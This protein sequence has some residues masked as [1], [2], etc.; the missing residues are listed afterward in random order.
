M[1]ERLSSELSSQFSYKETQYS[2]DTWEIVGEEHHS[3][4]FMPMA[5]EIVP[6]E[7]KLVD[8]MF[9]DYGGLSKVRTGK[10][11][12]LP[13]GVGPQDVGVQ[14]RAG[15]EEIEEL[16]KMFEQRLEHATQEALEEG[17]QLGLQEAE[18]L[19]KK[20]ISEVEARVS[21][22][23]KDMAAQLREHLQR[24]EKSAVELAV[25]ISRKIIDGAVDI[26]PEYIIPIVRET[27]NLAGGATVKKVRVS[28]QDMEF[29]QVVGVAKQLKEYDGS[30][31]FESD[32][33]IKAG[34]VVETSAGEIDYQL[35]VAWERVREKVIKAAR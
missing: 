32:S 22:T 15:A 25:N 11:W 13:E 28:P 18:E 19:A 3:D 27:L 21:Q 9:A 4:E 26:N 30:W 10:R 34:C 1:A 12:H 5:M 17:R 7:S 23:L 31:Q 24:T 6:R 29:I 35:D 16:K 8:P 33:T 14:R 2:D 20:K